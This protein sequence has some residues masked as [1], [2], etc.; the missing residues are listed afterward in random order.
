MVW[1]N[2]LLL[3]PY[4][5]V[6]WLLWH[7]QRRLSK[8]P[9]HHEIAPNLY[10]GRRCSNKKLPQGVGLIVDL[11]AEFTERREVRTG[12]DYLCVPMLDAS[13]SSVAAFDGLIKTIAEAASKQMPVYIHC[14]KG[15][16]R[17]AVVMVAA[18]MAS[19]NAVT[20]DEAEQKVRQARRGI[21]INAVQRHLLEQWAATQTPAF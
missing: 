20:L 5:G 1:G 2:V 8:E 13:V 10:L 4:L 3:F 9:P 19:Q 17:S 11:T 6:T 7:V 18:L 12:R 16:G 15:H 21:K 14:A